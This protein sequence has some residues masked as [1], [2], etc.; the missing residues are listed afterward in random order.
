[1]PHNCEDAVFSIHSYKEDVED[2]LTAETRA[3]MRCHEGYENGSYL[4]GE[5]ALDQLHQR[6]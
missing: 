1:M 6:R 3:G 2:F 4:D 5:I